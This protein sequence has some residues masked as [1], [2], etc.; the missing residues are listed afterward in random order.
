MRN[1]AEINGITEI[2]VLH[3]E[4]SNIENCSF[5]SKAQNLDHENSK[6]DIFRVFP[7]I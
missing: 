4:F 5:I 6:Y 3:T 7:Q 2:E 1:F